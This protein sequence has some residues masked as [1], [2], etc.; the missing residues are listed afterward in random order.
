[1]QGELRKTNEFRI[2][3]ILGINWAV[4]LI[5]SWKVRQGSPGPG[6]RPMSWDEMGSGDSRGLSGG[7]VPCLRDVAISRPKSANS[8][9]LSQ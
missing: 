9:P 7:R 5:Q 6:Q 1:M 8:H 3:Q 2:Y 4:L